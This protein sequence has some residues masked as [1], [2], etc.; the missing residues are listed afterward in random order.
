MIPTFRQAKRTILRRK[1]VSY[2]SHIACIE[3]M[4]LA[5]LGVKKMDT[6]PES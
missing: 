3:S 6:P 4:F 1:H 2:D 5:L